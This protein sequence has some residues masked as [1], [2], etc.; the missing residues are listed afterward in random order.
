MVG[1]ADS[2]TLSNLSSAVTVTANDR[3]S[4][5]GDSYTGG[6]VGY[7][8]GSQIDHANA[9]GNVNGLYYSGGI[10]GYAS[11]SGGNI[12]S[13]RATGKVSGTAYVGG[14]AGVVYNSSVLDS[15]ASGAVTEIGRAH[16]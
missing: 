12:V 3:G 8:T 1:L 5:R 6:V 13:S 16:V 4:G 9:S 14:L 7:F 15:S 10:V 11:L 2:G